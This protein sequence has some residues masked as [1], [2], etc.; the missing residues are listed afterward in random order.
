MFSSSHFARQQ[1]LLSTFSGFTFRVIADRWRASPLY[2]EVAATDP[3]R[4]FDNAD[5]RRFFAS[6]PPQTAFRRGSLSLLS[7][8]A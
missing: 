1:P 8:V 2:N 5:S 4:I 3:V 6:A 7:S